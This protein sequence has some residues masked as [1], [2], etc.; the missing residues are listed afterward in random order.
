MLEH[1]TLTAEEV[2]VLYYTGTNADVRPITIL[3]IRER[4]KPHTVEF[5]FLQEMGYIQEGATARGRRLV[6]TCILTESGRDALRRYAGDSMKELGNRI[7]TATIQPE[8]DRLEEL[9]DR[10]GKVLDDLRRRLAR[11]PAMHE[12]AAAE[13]DEDAHKDKEP[14]GRGPQTP[15]PAGP[16]RRRS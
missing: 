8:R 12:D 7:K 9:K 13:D 5:R 11:Q 3:E 14:R 1:R 15:T 2:L 16:R 10:L 4:L 6:G